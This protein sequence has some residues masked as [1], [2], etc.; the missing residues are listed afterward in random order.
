MVEIYQSA[1]VSYEGIDL[2]QPTVGLRIDAK[3][4]NRNDHRPAQQETDFKMYKPGVYQNALKNGHRLGVFASSDHISTHTA[5]GG[6]YAEEFTRESILEGIA[7]RRTIG[8]TDRIFAHFTCNGEPMG[9][10]LDCEG[11]PEFKITIE[12]TAPL[13]RVTLVRNESD[14]QVFEP[15][16]AAWETT[17]TD[18]KPLEGMNR[19]YLRIEQADGNMAW[20]SPVWVTIK[21]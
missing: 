9:S 8:A 17:Y 14:Y 16:K 10:A 11:A 19:Y 12:G 5:F 2:P 3:V 4:Y 15:V 1:R 18:P 7:A 21:P 20:V 13:K 6:V